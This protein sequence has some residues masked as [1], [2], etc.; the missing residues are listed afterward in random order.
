M[1]I[2]YYLIP[3]KFPKIETQSLKIPMITRNKTLSLKYIVCPK[4]T[5]KKR[6][7]K[8]IKRIHVNKHTIALNN[9]NHE[10]EPSYTIKYKGQSIYTHHFIIKG[11]IFGHGYI[12][13]CNLSCGAK[14]WL[15]TYD[16]IELYN[17]D[18]QKTGEIK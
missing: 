7:K 6:I 14:V 11:Q 13:E 10:S 15:E 18:M 5:S 4:K 8:T 3:L 9:K 2:I 12:S 1:L 17:L 16:K